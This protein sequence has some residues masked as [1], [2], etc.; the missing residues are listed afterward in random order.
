MLVGHV[1]AAEPQLLGPR[2]QHV[3]RNKEH[4]RLEGY[5]PHCKRKM[6]KEKATEHRD[7]SEI[8]RWQLSPL[9]NEICQVAV[10]RKGLRIGPWIEAGVDEPVPCHRVQ[11]N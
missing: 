2:F 11:T 6:S 1:P 3:E 4:G 10:M 8:A 9:T 7:T 5:L